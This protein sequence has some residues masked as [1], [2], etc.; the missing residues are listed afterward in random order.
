MAAKKEPFTLIVDTR[1]QLPYDFKS[2]VTPVLPFDITTATLRTG[3]YSALGYEISGVTSDRKSLA[4]ALNSFGA[5][6][7]RF[8][9]VIARMAEFDYAAVVIEAGWD[10]IFQVASGNA[11]IERASIDKIKRQF[12]AIEEQNAAIAAYVESTMNA[13]NEFK[14][15]YSKKMKPKTIIASVIAWEQRFGVHFHAVPGRAFAEQLTYRMIER[16][17]RDRRGA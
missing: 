3:D 17:V 14:K 11:V 1:E 2:V 7:E 15:T 5:D 10:E 12:P 6:R 8:E 4:D 16:F 9:A 13:A